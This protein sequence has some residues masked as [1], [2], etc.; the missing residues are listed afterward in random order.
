MP[1]PNHCIDCD[2]VA[3]VTLDNV[4]YCVECGLKEQ[5]KNRNEVKHDNR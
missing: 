4:P 2:K 5:Q 3:Q 1:M